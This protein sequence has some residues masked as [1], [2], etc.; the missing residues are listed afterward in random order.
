[1]EVARR[2][3]VDAIRE[4]DPTERF[5]TLG[6]SGSIDPH[7]VRPR[8]PA[9]TLD[10]VRVYG[11][12]RA[13]CLVGEELRSTRSAEATVHVD[14]EILGRI[15]Y[16]ESPPRRHEPVC[17]Q[18]TRWPP[19]PHCR[20]HHSP[21]TACSL[22]VWPFRSRA[23][24]EFGRFGVRPSRSQAVSGSLFRPG[25]SAFGR[26]GF[27]QFRSQPV[28]PHVS[29]MPKP[30]I[31]TVDD[32]PEVL[33]AVERDLRQHFRADYRVVKAAS[34]ARGARRRP[35]AQAARRADRALPRRRAHAAR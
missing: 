13:S 18:Q 15:D 7:P 22:G 16:A 8:A 24:S 25:I 35:P 30:V 5:L 4:T 14:R 28:S 17:A 10:K 21:P 1:M 23:V 9:E 2:E 32:D 6:A 11:S 27:R 34:G 26:F 19:P 31:L 33:N 20:H 3:L 29:C 12:G